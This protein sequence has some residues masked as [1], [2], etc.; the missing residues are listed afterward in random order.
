MKKVIVIMMAVVMSAFAITDDEVKR[1][2]AAGLSRNIAAMKESEWAETLAFAYRSNDA[3]VRR[4]VLQASGDALGAMS[5]SYA[6][7]A[8][9]ARRLVKAVDGLS[10]MV[11]VDANGGL[12]WRF[13]FASFPDDI[14]IKL[15][16]DAI[17][18]GTGVKSIS[19]GASRD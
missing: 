8:E 2:G 14:V 10:A 13:F 19:G 18:K 15:K 17:T 12:V 11:C 7:K 3:A 5:M 1:I 6:E 9:L 16:T 4:I